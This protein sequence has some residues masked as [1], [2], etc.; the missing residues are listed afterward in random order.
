MKRLLFAGCAAV[1]VALAAVILDALW[2]KH[3]RARH[4]E[5]Y[6][7]HT[8]HTIEDDD[9]VQ[10]TDPRTLPPGFEHRPA[11]VGNF[12]VRCSCG[13]MLDWPTHGRHTFENA[14]WVTAT[15]DG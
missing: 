6:A 12:Y 2:T 4:P 15:H 11:A 9:G 14:R 13:K 8:W 3:D 1:G 5:D 7:W 10:P